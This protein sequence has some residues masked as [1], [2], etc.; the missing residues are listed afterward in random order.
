MPVAKV[1][2]RSSVAA[3]TM[4]FVQGRSRTAGKMTHDVV[5]Q[6]LHARCASSAML[7]FRPTPVFT[8]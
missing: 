3:R 7:T 4:I 2:N 1:A 8:P 5:L 6:T